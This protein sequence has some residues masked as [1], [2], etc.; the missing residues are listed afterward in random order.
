MKKKKLGLKKVTL[1]D[2][3][4]SSLGMAGG[5]TSYWTCEDQGCFPQQTA[6][7][8][9]VAPSCQSL[10]DPCWTSDPANCC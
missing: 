10:C 7:C 2:L 1:R 8:N 4:P 9:T 5:Y 3:E 6:T